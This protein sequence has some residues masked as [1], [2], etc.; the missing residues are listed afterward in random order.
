MRNTQRG[1]GLLIVI[2]VFAVLFALVGVSLERNGDLFLQVHKHALETSAENLAE[3]GVTYAVEQLLQTAGQFH[4]DEQLN[5]EPG[6]TCAVSVSRL[7]ASD[8]IQILST[9]RAVGA[10]RVGDVV[11]TLRVVVQFSQ[12][13]AQHPIILLAREEL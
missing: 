12:E 7:T 13:N 4:G 3:A 2:I 9:G 1:S 11:K 5:L 6:G 8:K 10:G